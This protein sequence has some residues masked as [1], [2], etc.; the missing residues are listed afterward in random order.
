MPDS[1]EPIL[2]HMQG[3]T[4]YDSLIGWAEWKPVPGLHRLPLELQGEQTAQLS[5]D[6]IMSHPSQET[7]SAG[8]ATGSTGV[9]GTSRLRWRP[10]ADVELLA[11]SSCTE[12]HLS[13]NSAHLLS[14]LT[15][16]R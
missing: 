12:L 8:P 1:Y 5:F 9:S 4:E 14:P 16:M 7:F 3:T 11:E 10:A 13:P 6:L 2:W 15:N